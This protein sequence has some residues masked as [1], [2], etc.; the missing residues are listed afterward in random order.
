MWNALLQRHHHFLIMFLLWRLIGSS[1]SFVIQIFEYLLFRE[2][3]SDLWFGNSR[4]QS[5]IDGY[6]DWNFCI[7][8]VVNYFRHW[9][10]LSPNDPQTPVHVFH[11]LF[12]GHL[13][14]ANL[15]FPLKLLLTWNKNQENERIWDN[16]RIGSHRWT[17]AWW[18]WFLPWE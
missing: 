16:K 3:R 5:R 10:I 15:Y 1:S 12:W 13:S 18:L 4:H 6:S 9:N 2:P 11:D 17:W 8:A 14:V 7:H